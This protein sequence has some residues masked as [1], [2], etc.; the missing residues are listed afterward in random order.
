MGDLTRLVA[1]FERFLLRE[2]RSPATVRTYRW[3]LDDLCGFLEAQG[4]QNLPELSQHRPV[5]EAWQDSLLRRQLRPRS[6]SLAAT[7]VRQFFRWAADHDYC[8]GKLERWLAGVRVKA[9]RP[10][11]LAPE[12]LAAVRAY[13]AHRPPTPRGRLLHFRNRALFSYLLGTGARVSEALQVP[14]RGFENAT[15]RQKGGTE[16]RLTCPPSVMPLIQEYLGERKDTCPSLFASGA[17]QPMTPLQVRQVWLTTTAKL[18]LPRFTT[19]QLRHTFATEL[20]DN[21]V[22]HVV[23]AELLGHHG[24]GTIMNYAQVRE[25]KRQAALSVIDGMLTL[26]V[27]GYV[28]PRLKRRRKRKLRKIADNLS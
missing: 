17:G 4:V 18:G 22:D 26:P 2:D 23:V 10:R 6:R 8:E 20:L 27:E 25:G 16:K 9:L 1:D 24:L 7:A 5:L 19:H 13:F 12:V 11:P 21:G 28:L 14:R 15:V 3:A